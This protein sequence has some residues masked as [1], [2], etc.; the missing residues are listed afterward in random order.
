MSHSEEEN[1]S[2][3]LPLRVVVAPDLLVQR[4]DDE[5]V[6][7]SMEKDRYFGLND[8]GARMWELLAEDGDVNAALS[9]LLVEYDVD[10]A[11]LRRDLASLIAQCQEQG[12]VTA[13]YR[14]S[15]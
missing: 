6:M 12:L 13:E 10:A 9:T 3:P 15:A 5:I 7:L 11:T 1:R 8:V 14:A 4:M 2:V